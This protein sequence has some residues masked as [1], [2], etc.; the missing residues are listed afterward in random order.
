[1]WSQVWTWTA[2]N[3]PALIM[4][5]VVAV[6]VWRI[7]K[8]YY[9]RIVE[10]EKTVKK[11]ESQI[12]TLPCS[13]HDQINQ[14]ILEKLTTITTYL[15]TKDSK[16]SALF[17]QKESPRKLNLLGEQLF[18]NSG[19][20]KFLDQNKNELLAAIAAKA[21]NTALDVENLAIEV[22][23]SQLDSDIFN[24]LKQW[25]YNSPSLKIDV[26]G[27]KQEEAVTL[28]DICFVLSLS[29]RDMYLEA[30]PDLAQE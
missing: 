2:D 10:A 17:S 5:A 26:Q 3:Y 13:A 25:V 30:H 29:L 23:I 22:L 6:V 15:I 4:M 18:E 1:M 7:A 24:E 20:Q 16:A 21:P 27:Q 14:K 19:G 12:Q 11:V 8:F 9:T 28:N